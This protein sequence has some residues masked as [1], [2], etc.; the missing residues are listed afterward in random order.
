[1]N[2]MIKKSFYT[3]V[4]FLIS[5]AIILIVFYSIIG[6]YNS[7]IHLEDAAVN[8][9]NGDISICYYA[10]DTEC[11]VIKTFDITGKLLY[12]HQI[13]G[14]TAYLYYN[15][16]KLNVA[17]PRYDIN[18]VFDEN[19]NEEGQFEYT[20]FSQL[21]NFNQ[22]KGQKNKSFELN[23]HT[24]CYE[25]ASFFNHIFSDGYSKLFIKYP[26]YTEKVIWE[27]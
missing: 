27:S 14:Y 4:L 2:T 3:K 1:M 25:E 11:I 19:G 16:N 7:V 18:Y 5:V 21:N 20:S 12:E 10:E 24:Y 26:D 8:S 22:F 15:N 9:S 13:K 6:R 23:N 17:V